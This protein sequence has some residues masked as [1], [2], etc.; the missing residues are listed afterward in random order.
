MAGDSVGTG[1]D[2][3]LGPSSWAPGCP[4][5]QEE[6]ILEVRARKGNSYLCLL[7]FKSYLSAAQVLSVRSQVSPS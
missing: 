3:S 2:V 1:R 5:A 7:L 6:N 4:G